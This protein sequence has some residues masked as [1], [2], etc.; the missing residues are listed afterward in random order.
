MTD[1]TEHTVIIGGSS[2]IGLATARK[3]SDEGARVLLVGR[4]AQRLEVAAARVGGDFI[5]ADVTD[6]DADERII[7]T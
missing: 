3:L 1:R 7:A 5:A 2:G 6:S 4:D